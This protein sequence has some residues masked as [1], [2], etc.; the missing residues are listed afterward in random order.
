MGQV[1]EIDVHIFLLF[2]KLFLKWVLF[3]YKIVI[4][5]SD[6]TKYVLPIA[7]N[8][9]IHAAISSWTFIG[10]IVKSQFQSCIQ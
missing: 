1:L 8:K 3:D 2:C 10:S 7:G 5:M 4:A 9:Y 6:V